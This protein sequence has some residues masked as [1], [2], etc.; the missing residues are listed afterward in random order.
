MRP[1]NKAGVRGALFFIKNV[2]DRAYI[3]DRAV[4]PV[5]RFADEGFRG[6]FSSLLQSTAFTP[7]EVDVTLRGPPSLERS[8]SASAMV[9]SD[10]FPFC[11][12]YLE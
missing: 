8:L 11:S 7:V 10:G 1:I 4:A 6:E 12:K 3:A 2:C 5:T 9:F